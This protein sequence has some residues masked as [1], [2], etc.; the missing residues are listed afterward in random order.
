MHILKAF[1][2]LK[3][4]EESLSHLYAWYSELFAGDAEAALVFMRLSRA[5]KAHAAL[6]D[7]EKHVVQK[8]PDLFKSMEMDME[9]VD[10]VSSRIGVLRTSAAPALDAAVKISL[11]FESS[12]SEFHYKNAIKQA[13]PSISRL[14][15]CLGKS[16]RNHL[17]ELLEFAKVRGYLAK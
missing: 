3:R 4:L 9:A 7:Y 17:D 8:N 13:N 2:P 10:V 14:Q 5:E 6:L 12:A 1:G 15:D 16:D 11:E